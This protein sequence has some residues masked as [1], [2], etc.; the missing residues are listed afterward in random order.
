MSQTSNS[1]TIASQL[2]LEERQ[3]LC[4]SL[5][6]SV[7]VNHG[8]SV[9]IQARH[10]LES[11]LGTDTWSFCC[12]QFSSVLEHWDTLGSKER[13][14]LVLIASRILLC[15]CVTESVAEELLLKLVRGIVCFRDLAEHKDPTDES[16]TN[17]WWLFREY[18]ARK[19]TKAEITNT[20]SQILLYTSLKAVYMAS[21]VETLTDNWRTI[22]SCAESVIST[23]LTTGTLEMGFCCYQ[24]LEMLKD[25]ISERFACKRYI[26]HFWNRV[27]DCLV[28]PSLFSVVTGSI[29]SNIEMELLQFMM[30]PSKS[31]TELE[32]FYDKV[33][34]EGV[35]ILDLIR[36]IIHQTSVDK[37][38]DQSIKVLIG[39][40]QHSMKSLGMGPTTKAIVEPLL[41][42]TG[43]RIEDSSATATRAPLY[44]FLHILSREHDNVLYTFLVNLANICEE[45]AAYSYR[46]HECFHFDIH[47]DIHVKKVF[48]SLCMDTK[49]SSLCKKLGIVVELQSPSIIDLTESD[50]EEKKQKKNAISKSPVIKNAG[51]SKSVKRKQSTKLND[52]VIASKKMKVVENGETVRMNI[53]ST[54]ANMEKESPSKENRITSK[55]GTLHQI[56]ESEKNENFENGSVEERKDV[57]E[58]KRNDRLE[59]LPPAAAVQNVEPSEKNLAL[60]AETNVERDKEKRTDA[61]IE[62]SA[63]VNLPLSDKLDSESTISSCS[64]STAIEPGSSA[65]IETNGEPKTHS[66]VQEEIVS[67]SEQKA[68][69]SRDKELRD[70]AEDCKEFLSVSDSESIPYLQA[71]VKKYPRK[72]YVFSRIQ[73]ELAEFVLYYLDDEDKVR[74]I[75]KLYESIYVDFIRERA[76]RISSLLSLTAEFLYIIRQ[77]YV[78]AIRDFLNV[79]RT[80]MIVNLVSQGPSGLMKLQH[81]YELLCLDESEIHSEGAKAFALLQFNQD[82]RILALSFYR[83]DALGFLLDIASIFPDFVRNNVEFFDL[84]TLVMNKDNMKAALELFQNGTIQMFSFH[85]G[86]EKYFCNM[87]K[88]SFEWQSHE[89]QN[90]L[91]KLLL[92]DVSNR[93]LEEQKILA[94]HLII[95]IRTELSLLSLE[96]SRALLEVFSDWIILQTPNQ[97]ML[98]SLFELGQPFSDMV[99]D[100]ICAWLVKSTSRE[101][102]VQLLLNSFIEV[103]SGNE[104]NHV[105]MSRVCAV[106]QACC[107]RLPF[108]QFLNTER[109]KPLMEYC[110]QI[111]QVKEIAH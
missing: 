20:C 80:S 108:F 9:S 59:S 44:K 107:R 79:S 48:T 10:L 85:S 64:Y 89:R 3:L 47:N 40:V 39:L 41:V 71:I 84:L 58:D 70:F 33:T 42:V 67:T 65:A 63:A 34:K 102:L 11:L 105:L 27:R 99:S 98:F 31:S 68:D 109:G 104:N 96:Q 61:I 82:I 93:I 72:E 110:K 22:L 8:N 49:M 62:G 18:V 75:K 5:L 53:S 97:R 87:V 83:D 54:R 73:Q 45:N 43:A 12:E 52:K 30:Q 51:Q 81:S 25:T 106:L 13:E 74:R 37:G 76:H 36:Y 101:E 14:A 2:S 56:V 24:T 35:V 50:K 69:S 7:L 91:W 29:P 38:T 21:R 28:S 103:M 94:F 57:V 32:N 66:I 1:P 95:Q 78:D 111:F 26:D 19:F 23:F 77:R 92:K 6:G 100:I 90:Y 4:T 46:V 55:S 16:M 86:E 17:V 88:R 15:E 60:V